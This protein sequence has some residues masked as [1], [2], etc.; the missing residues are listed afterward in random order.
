MRDRNGGWDRRLKACSEV[1][2]G[3]RSAATGWRSTSEM[4]RFETEILTTRKNL[5]S[6]MD[7][8]GEWIDRVAQRP[9]PDQARA[10]LCGA[11]G[12][13]TRPRAAKRRQ[14][15]EVK[16]KLAE[17]NRAIHKAYKELT[18]KIKME[19]GCADCGFNSNP[20]ALQ[21]DHLPEHVKLCK[22]SSMHGYAKEKVLKEI[23]KCEVVCGNCHALR[24]EKRRQQ[25]KTENET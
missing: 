15:P 3:K 5:K 12:Q 7:P 11:V 18:N 17:Y 4:S 16:E 2:G 22:V 1:A 14:R 24:T 20:C 19:K 23:E 9:P 8:P 10:V 6:C 21:F 13:H 25:R